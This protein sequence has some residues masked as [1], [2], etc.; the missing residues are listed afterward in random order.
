MIHIVFCQFT[1]THF[2]HVA[3][4]NRRK[5]QVTSG[6]LIDTRHVGKLPVVDD[7]IR[8][9]NNEK[10]YWTILKIASKLRS[11]FIGMGVC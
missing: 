10:I 2:V 7:P 4:G 6:D 3:N 5:A 8:T 1:K 11:C 9:L